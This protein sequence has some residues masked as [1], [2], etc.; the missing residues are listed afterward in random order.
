M[1]YAV[2]T[3]FLPFIPFSTIRA[4]GGGKRQTYQRLSLFL[5]D[6]FELLLQAASR[7]NADRATPDVSGFLNAAVLPSRNETQTAELMAL[8]T[9]RNILRL[10][11]SARWRGAARR[12]GQ[13]LSDK[14]ALVTNFHQHLRRQIGWTQ[15]L[16]R[17]SLVSS[18]VSDKGRCAF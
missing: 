11:K 1:H 13:Y 18:L 15:L 7:N 17:R 6:R 2:V 10:K 8:D 5:F 9:C 16:C 14:E 12:V 3:C 4:F